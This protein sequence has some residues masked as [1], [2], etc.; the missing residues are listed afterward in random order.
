MTGVKALSRFVRK[1][2][3]F[4]NRQIEP[5]RREILDTGGV[6]LMILGIVAIVTAALNH[7]LGTHLERSELVDAGSVFVAAGGVLIGLAGAERPRS[8]RAR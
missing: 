5:C 1:Q 7:H 4:V 3:G 8:R 2:I 6:A